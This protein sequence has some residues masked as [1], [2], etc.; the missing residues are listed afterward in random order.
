MR[1]K[2]N[3]LSPSGHRQY[4]LAFNVRE[5]E[6]LWGIADKFRRR[7]PSE[8]K[9]AQEVKSLVASTC[10]G[11][12]QALDAAKE[13]GDTGDRASWPRKYVK[14]AEQRPDGWNSGKN[15]VKNKLIELIKKV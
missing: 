15:K 7:M 12:R 11:L 10:V 13:L 1:Y 8:G 9:P 5:L 14:G 2:Y 4:F 6:L 3:E